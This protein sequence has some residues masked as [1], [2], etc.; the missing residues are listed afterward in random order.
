MNAV[1]EN[2]WTALHGAA[3]TGED[4]I[5]QFLVE[6]GAKMDVKDV[7]EQTPLSIAQGEIVAKVLDFTKKTVRSSPEHGELAAPVG[8]YPIIGF[9]TPTYGSYRHKVNSRHRFL[10]TMP[11]IAPDHRGTYSKL[12]NKLAVA[13]SE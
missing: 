9:N 4:E 8:R 6:K 13:A 3:Y 7:F 2:G 10:S 5:A 12:P 1:G 11:P